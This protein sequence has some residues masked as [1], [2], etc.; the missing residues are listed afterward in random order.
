M[1]ITVHLAVAI[2][3]PLLAFLAGALIGSSVRTGSDS[4]VWSQGYWAGHYAAKN[5]ELLDD[6]PEPRLVGEE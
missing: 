4:D 1:E 2:A 5:A 3:G 6:L